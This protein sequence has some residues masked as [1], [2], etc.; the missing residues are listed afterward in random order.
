MW[1]NIILIFGSFYLGLVVLVYFFQDKLLFLPN[2]PGRQL[3]AAPT[4]IGL[5][6]EDLTLQ[7]ADGETL[8][9]WFIPARNT[10]AVLL[11][12]HGNAGNISHRLDSIRIFNQLGF[13][14]LIFDYR[15]YGKSSGTP[16]EQGTYTDAH[17]AWQYLREQRGIPENNI[18]LFGRSLGGAVAAQ[19]AAET[20]PAALILESTFT[21]V[22]D[23][24]AKVYPFLPVRLLATLN[25]NTQE[26]MKKTQCPVLV[27]HSREDEIIPF[28]FGQALYETANAPKKSLEVQGDHN[29]G[30][31]L[32][33]SAYSMGIYN[34]MEDIIE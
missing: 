6:Y 24:G 32:S 2:V 18:I 9:A 16:S 30:F 31:L 4:D 19:L 26:A 34:F 33:G 11:F 29:T 15:G 3:Q 1:L 7:T 21:S 12:F 5:K 28:S 25:Y 20:E 17:T 22:P 13:D 10:R 14:V 8:H 27:I 23:M